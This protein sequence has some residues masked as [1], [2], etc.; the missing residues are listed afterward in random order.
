ME[1]NVGT[2][3]QRKKSRMNRKIPWWLE[4]ETKSLLKE[5]NYALRTKLKLSIFPYHSNGPNT[6]AGLL[7][8]TQFLQEQ[9]ETLHRLS[10]TKPRG[11]L[12]NICADDLYPKN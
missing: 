12:I 3:R 10:S 8:E 6:H 7:I 2:K 4:T 11:S 1:T 5:Q 9:K